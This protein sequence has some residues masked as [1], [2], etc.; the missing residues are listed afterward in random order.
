[1]ADWINL[2]LNNIKVGKQGEKNTLLSF[3]EGTF[4]GYNTFVLNKMLKENKGVAGLSFT[5]DW[6]FT[7]TKSEKEGDVWVEK[8]RREITGSEFAEHYPENVVK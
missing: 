6:K 8:D 7:L 1:M 3:K 2:N 5:A 4:K